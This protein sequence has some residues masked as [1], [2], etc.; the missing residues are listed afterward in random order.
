MNVLVYSILI[1]LRDW[2]CLFI[3][4]SRNPPKY[5][6]CAWENRYPSNGGKLSD[7][8]NAEHTGLNLDLHPVNERRRYKLTPSLIGW[9]Q[10]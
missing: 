1:I 7:M 5:Q 2:Q 6:T 3:G 8:N 9:A 10:T 4:I